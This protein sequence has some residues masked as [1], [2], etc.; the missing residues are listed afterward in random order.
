MTKAA[1]IYGGNS[2]QSRLKGILDKAASYFKKG[3]IDTETI[4]VHDLPAKDLILANFNSEPILKANKTVEEADIVVVLTPVYK[5]AYTGI[6]KTYL[7]LLPQKGLEGKT[8]LPLVLGGSFGHLLAID[9]ALKPVLSALGATNI[10]SGAYV[11][12]TQVEKT[13][14]LKYVLASEISERLDRVLAL[15]K[16]EADR[17]LALK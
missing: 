4:F 10:L 5:A 17:Y 6:L 12:D 11:L 8:V 15:S 16:E 3:G 1:I 14:D 13:E 9:Y 2:K 7:D